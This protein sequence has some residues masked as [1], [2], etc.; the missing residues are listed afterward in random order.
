MDEFKEIFADPLI[1]ESMHLISTEMCAKMPIPGC[2]M[3][4]NKIFDF[5]ID[6]LS[7]IDSKHTCSFFGVCSANPMAGGDWCADCIDG[8]LH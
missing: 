2:V 5:S 6:K 3:I 4:M 8:K 1:R 7:N